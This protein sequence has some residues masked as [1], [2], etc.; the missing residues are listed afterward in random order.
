[1]RPLTLVV[2]AVIAAPA[3][4]A[5]QDTTASPLDW[6]G[7]D[8]NRVA[9]V[10]AHGKPQRYPRLVL[11]APTD[12]L[13]PHWLA[14]FG[15]TLDAGLTDLRALIGGPYPWQRIGNRPIVFFFSPGRFVSHSTGQDTVF[16]SL[17]RI[18]R[19]EAPFLHE[20]AHELLTPKGPFYADEYADSLEEERRASRFPQWLNEGFPDYLA[21]T[22][23][24]TTSFPEGDVFAIGGLDKVDSTCAARLAANPRSSEILEKVGGQGGLEALL[25]EDR[26]LVAPT[27]YA[28]SQAFTKYLVDRIGVKAVTG[29]FPEIPPD[30]WKEKIE[31]LSGQPIA[32]IRRAWMDRIGIRRS[33]L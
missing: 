13:D 9:F 2:L 18:R 31:R 15:D 1:M 3:G 29:L 20:A 17:N 7:D 33:G 19:G 10:T 26:Q 24:K 6:W 14:G 27:F 28:C 23:A 21:Q 22:V 30:R 12:S 8:S 32:E 25:T 5:S 4:L 11:W 16:I